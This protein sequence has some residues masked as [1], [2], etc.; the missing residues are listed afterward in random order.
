MWLRWVFLAVRDRSGRATVT[1]P[2]AVPPVGLRAALS[3]LAKTQADLNAI[4][5]EISDAISEI[6]KRLRDSVSVRIELKT[7]TGGLAF[8]KINNQ[9]RMLWWRDGSEE[10]A[11]SSAPRDIRAD[12]I[13]SIKA[14]IQSGEA[15]LVSAIN[16]RRAAIDCARCLLEAL[17]VES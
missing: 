10:I 4:D 5:D 3:A 15:Q 9:W 1:K 11:L 14:L 17:K 12:S 16:N 8:G 2:S 6:E 13:A 7:D